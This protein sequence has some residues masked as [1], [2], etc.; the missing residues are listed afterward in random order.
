MSVATQVSVNEY[1]TTTYRP[2]CDYVDGEVV[3][4]NLGEQTH[5]RAQGCSVSLLMSQ[6]AQWGIRVLPEQRVQVKSN[7]YRVPDVCVLGPGAPRE[8]II[9][10]PPFLC[11]E[12]LSE[13][14]TMSDIMERVEEY[15]AMG[16]P[17]VWVVDPLRRRGYHY[18]AEGMREAKDGLLRTS[19]PD[20]VVPLAALFD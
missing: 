6:E 2:D 17:Y 20:L 19:N 7:R 10:H 16:V 18:T 4:R 1:L 9:T 11:I 3:K 8:E 13:D 14:D 5:A 12:I 15:L